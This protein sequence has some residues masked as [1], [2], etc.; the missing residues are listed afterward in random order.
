MCTCHRQVLGQNYPQNNSHWF[1]VI[2]SP[3]KG[4]QPNDRI[5]PEC[6]H[7][8]TP[9]KD[10]PFHC[11]LLFGSSTACNLSSRLES[12]LHHHKM[13]QFCHCRHYHT[14]NMGVELAGMSFPTH[15]L[16]SPVKMTS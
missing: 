16:T 10:K 9:K 3:N 15:K 11:R 8:R 5:T 4:R 12:S 13:E 1:D 7:T 14:S 2:S 6:S